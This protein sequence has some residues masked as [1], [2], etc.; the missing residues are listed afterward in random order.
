MIGRTLGHYQITEKLGEGGMGVVYRARDPRLGRDVAIKVLPGE[1]AGSPERLQRFEREARAVAA[2]N[3][4]SI[5]TVFDVGMHDGAPYVVTELLEGETLRAFVSRHSSTPRQ[6]L[7]FML[8]AARGLEAAHAKGIIHRDIKPENLFVTTDGRVKV[9]DFGLAK[10]TASQAREGSAATESDPTATGQMLGTPGYM[11]PEQVRGL[12]LDARTDVFSFGVVLYELLSGKHPFRRETP[13]ATLSAI[14][15]ETPPELSVTARHVSPQ[16]AAI[17]VRCLEKPREERFASGHDLVVAL[18]AVTAGASGL[19][20]GAA[21]IEER[22]PYPGLSSFTEKDAA[23]FFGREEEV[24]ALWQRLQNRKLLAVI[25]PSGTGK[26]SFVRAGV[27]PGAPE[28]WRCLWVTPG[29]R[30]FAAVARSLVPELSNDPETLQRLVGAETGEELTAALGV[31]RRRQG[32]ALVVVDQFEELF[33]LNPKEVQE[34]FA[35]FLGRL[36]SEADVHVLISLRDDFLMRCQEHAA[37]TVVFTELTPL[38]GLTKEALRRALVEPAKKF[39]YRFEDEALVDEMVESVEGARAALPLLAFAI[40]RLWEKRDR[41][42]KLLTR[43]AHEEIGGVAGALAQHAEAVMDRI[44]VGQEVVREIFRNLVTSQ[45][46]RAVVDRDELLSAFPEKGVAEGV[47]RELIDARLV[48]SYEVEGREGEASHHRVEVVHESLLKAWP[49]LVWWQA[50]DEEG[51]VLRDQLK[52]AA[53]LWEE[54]GRPADL[55]WSGTSFREYEL[56]RD[57]YPGALTALEED[58]AR[59]TTDRARRMRRLRRAVLIAAVAILSVVVIVV[60]WSRQQAAKA[61]DQAHAEAGRHEAAKVLAL[62]RLRLADHPNAAL[63]YAI[64]SLER[65]DNEPARRFAV[66]ALWQ[67][68]PALYLTDPVFP[69]GLKLSPDGHWMAL[70]SMDGGLAIVSRETGERQPLS[71]SGDSPVGFTSDSQRLVTKASSG[72]PTV[73]HVWTLPEGRLEHTL[74]HPGESYQVLVDDQI[75]TFAFEGTAASGEQSAI[76]RRLSVN[77]D[78]QQVLGRWEPHGFTGLDVD[79]SG[80]CIFSIQRGR[81]LQQRLDALAAPARAI[82]A[83]EGGV[84]W[85]SV[86][87]WRDRT[88]TGDGGGEVRIWNVPSTRLERTLKSPADAQTIAL[89]PKGRFLAT[90]PNHGMSPRSRFLFDLAA[91]RTAEPLALLGGEYGWLNALEFSPD[92]SWLA[93]VNVGNVTLWNMRGSRSIVIGRQEP[94]FT[95]LA[96]TRDGHL[97]SSS[98]EGVLRRWPLSPAVGEGVQTLWSQPGAPVGFILEADPEGRF[99]V[100]AKRLR[101]TVL[102]IPLDGSKAVSYQVKAATGIIVGAVVSTLDPGGRFLAMRVWSN[103]RPEL[104]AIRI[105]DLA[106]GE[107]RTLDTYPKGG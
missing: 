2:L 83:H 62:G 92:G 69:L 66:E 9:L 89:D 34:R 87:R 5:L 20:A 38:G 33:T 104:N 53:H 98:D 35:A 10:L 47:L 73:L 13:M 64:A 27:I 97:L 7:A 36:A 1:V 88:V 81:V 6:V 45:G 44:G 79:L 39:G 105:L 77:G 51:A 23:H 82:G 26:T 95:T 37:L 58:F 67:G 19:E 8:Q 72:A 18:E 4:P 49:R 65:S 70:G 50:Q 12:P 30:P 3:H 60:S 84:A 93:S 11:S 96:F 102:V 54:R 40:S 16:V 71:S 86:H 94:P 90:G 56:W 15:E 100:L 99:V 68:P 46:T 103:G 28:G 80:T 75:L 74:Q 17:V 101:G 48:T 106:T 32:E 42:K 41:E 29:N 24:K 31:W 21:G 57:R 61:R 43:A 25:G 55:L 78:A 52:Q 63:A 91:P 76:V 22:S 85:F 59:A 14:L 107:E